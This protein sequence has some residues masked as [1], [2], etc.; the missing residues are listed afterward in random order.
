MFPNVLVGVPTH[1]KTVAKN[2]DGEIGKG[3]HR[4]IFPRRVGRVINLRLNLTSRPSTGTKAP[5]P[6]G[7]VKGNGGMS[8]LELAKRPKWRQY[9]K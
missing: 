2:D 1:G 3:S 9:K 8:D 4:C 7:V 6:R 5:V